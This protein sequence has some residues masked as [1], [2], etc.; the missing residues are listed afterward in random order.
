MNNVFQVNEFVLSHFAIFWISLSGFV[1][2]PSILIFLL[3]LL[4]QFRLPL[5]LILQR[6]HLLFVKLKLSRRCYHLWWQLLQVCTISNFLGVKN[7]VKVSMKI[8]WLD[9]LHQAWKFSKYVIIVIIMCLPK[10]LLTDGNFNSL[11][12]QRP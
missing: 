11:V 3:W 7:W 2:F 8:S 1:L 4:Q 6:K 12:Y 9:S 10:P 5:Q